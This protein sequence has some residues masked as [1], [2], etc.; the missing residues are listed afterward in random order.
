MIG[1]RRIKKLTLESSGGGSLCGLLGLRVLER[2]FL[3]LADLLGLLLGL[4]LR[5]S[6]LLLLH[7]GS[8]EQVM[9]VLSLCRE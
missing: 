5:G 9:R 3:L 2:L 4:L 1:I 8:R 6:L 7:L